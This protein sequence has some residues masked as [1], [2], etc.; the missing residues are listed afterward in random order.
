MAETF[1]TTEL[2][3]NRTLGLLGAGNMAEALAR[4]IV[5]SG[6][7][8]AG[9]VIAS[10][11][12]PERR[13]LFK[14]KLG[15]R[16]TEDNLAVVGAADI[17]V[18]CVKPQQAAAVVGGIASAFDPARHLLATICAGVSTARLEALLPERAR[19]VR[20]MPNTPMLVGLGA[21][22]VAG[23]KNASARDIA[24]I[25]ALFAAASMTVRVE[26]KMIDAVTGLSGSG[27]AYLFYLV[28]A[29][30]DA[31]LAEGF[32]AEHARALAVRTVLGAS[33]MLDETNL[34]PEELRRRVTS[35]NGT[36]QAAI[37]LMEAAGVKGK[38]T[39]AVRRAAERSREL[40]RS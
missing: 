14:D 18:L 23:G 33:K 10:D 5:Q 2:L 11:V 36:T 35:P 7:I 20:V 17:L 29:M 31:G 1:S 19:V 39:A 16:V 34:S 4:G 32:S 21:S 3:G 15:A 22:A 26:E 30:I 25:E 12:S 38:I 24:T 9:N 13:A 28:E 6:A 37:E 27:P 40:G 8:A